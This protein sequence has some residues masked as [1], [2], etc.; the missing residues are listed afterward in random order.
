MISVVIISKDEPSL[1]QTLEGVCRATSKLRQDAEVIVVDA[2]EGRLDEIRKRY[3]DRVT[4]LA[5]KQPLGVM[6]TIPHQRN[7]GV[8]AAH[9]DIIVFTDAWLRPRGRLAGALDVATVRS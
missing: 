8:H 2:S 3:E 7:V 4:W 1:E 5:Y 6:I 9:G